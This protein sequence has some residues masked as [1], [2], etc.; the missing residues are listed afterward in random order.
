MEDWRLK[1]GVKGEGS[2]GFRFQ[3]EKSALRRFVFCGLRACGAGK[4][5]R[6]DDN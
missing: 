1:S 4:R 5:E 2:E 6:M 3:I